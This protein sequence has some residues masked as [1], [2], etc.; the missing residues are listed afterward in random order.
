MK[1]FNKLLISVLALTILGLGLVSAVVPFGVESIVEGPSTR[2]PEDIADSTPAL[3]GN[4]TEISIFGYTITQAWQGYFGNVTGTIQLADSVDNVM[5]N[6]SLADPEGEVY[7]SENGSI[8]WVGT[9]CWDMN[10]NIN[11]LEAAY[12]I[13]SDDVDGIDETFNWATHSEFY[14]NNIQIPAGECNSTRIFDSTG[15]GVNEN[16]E[17]VILEGGD[18]E[19]IWTAIIEEAAINGFDGAD[20]DFQMLVPEDGHGT[21]IATRPYY[22]YVELE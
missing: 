2:A 11:S 5:Y 8:N 9:Y 1:R 7:A 6:W 15:T 14:V 17:Q 4:V 10:T 19:I 16:Y 18:G 3:A 20:H 12:G 22:F 21:D 13:A